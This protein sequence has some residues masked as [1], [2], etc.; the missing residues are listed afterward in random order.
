MVN[1]HTC[2]NSSLNDLMELGSG[3]NKSLTNPFTHHGT[4]QQCW[5]SWA[6]GPAV[7]QMAVLQHLRMPTAI[8]LNRRTTER[9]SHISGILGEK[10]NFVS[11]LYVP[12]L[13]MLAS[14]RTWKMFWKCQAHS[15][16][17]PVQEM[18]RKRF[19]ATL[20]APCARDLILGNVGAGLF[21]H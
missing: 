9:S 5:T 18:S 20:H 7:Q 8:R 6:K 17:N 3:T 2:I 15:H 19:W 4:A 1:L 10:N 13:A 11:T 21:P 14:S 12:L 16:M